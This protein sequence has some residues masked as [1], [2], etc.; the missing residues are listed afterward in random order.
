MLTSRFI[1][2]LSLDWD[3]IPQDSYARG[4]R[5]LTRLEELVFTHDV[6]IFAGEN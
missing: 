3:A 2:S 5:A 4:I 6:T 1:W